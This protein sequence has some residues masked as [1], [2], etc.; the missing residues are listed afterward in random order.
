M[1]RLII[2]FTASFSL[3]AFAQDHIPQTNRDGFVTLFNGGN[4]DGWHLKIRSGDEELAKKVYA[5][6]DG[7]VHV[8]NDQFPQEY[9][10]NTGVNDTH[11]LF[12]TN[13]KYSRYIFQFE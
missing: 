11:G 8:F 12:Y 6:E 2:L 10:L 3:T 13:K 1:I 5:I 9:N 4:W 7:M